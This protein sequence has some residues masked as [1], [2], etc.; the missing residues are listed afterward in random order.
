MSGGIDEAILDAFLEEVIAHA[1]KIG[2]RDCAGYDRLIRYR[3]DLG[4]QQY[5]PHAYRDRDNVRE[6]R[7]EAADLCAYA[8]FEHL[9][10]LEDPLEADPHRAHNLFMAAVY[11][12]LADWHARAAIRT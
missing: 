3:L 5:G 10:D 8:L 1:G 4:A 7:E 11:G 9:K 12:A 6:L 2:G